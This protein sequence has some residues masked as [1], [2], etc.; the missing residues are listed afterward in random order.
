MVIGSVE[1]PQCVKCSEVLANES[2]KPA[3][4][5]RHLNT[6][7]NNLNNKD[8]AFFKAKVRGVKS[9]R[10][11][12]SGSFQNKNLAAIEASYSAA[13]K[14]AQ[15]KKPRT[16]AENLIL[17]CA[18]EIVCLMLGP[19]YANK[20]SSLSVSNNTIKRRISDMSNDILLQIV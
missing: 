13:L 17:P 10:L 16:I 2:M 6:K 5:Q 3:K 20:L 14:V 12:A 18:K 8:A 15:A 4:L 11:D 1:R 19:E 9:C 7:H